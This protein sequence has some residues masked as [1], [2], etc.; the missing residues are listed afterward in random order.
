VAKA[1]T[2]PKQQ[3][4]TLF[5]AP[6]SAGDPVFTI[7]DRYTPRQLYT[8]V[9]GVP[10]RWPGQR[11]VHLVHNWR[12]GGS[13]LTALL[14]V[15]LH[16]SYL[17]VGHPFTRDGWP[18]NYGLHP[19]QITRAEQLIQWIRAQPS[20]AILAG[21][22][23]AGMAAKLGLKDAELWITLREPAA[24][25][26]SGLLRFHRKALKS[27]HPDGGYVGRTKGH[28][29]STAAEIE[30]VSKQ[31]LSHELNGL[32]RRI[33]GYSMLPSGASPHPEDDLETCR[34]LDERPVDQAC[35][36]LAMDHLNSSAWIYL[37]EQVIPSLLLLEHHYGL[38]PLIHPC[39]NLVHN[40]QWNGAGITRLQES[41]LTHHRGLLESLNAWDVKLYT[42]A[43]RLFWKRWKQADIDPDRLKARRILQGKPLLHQK[44]L[45]QPEEAQRQMKSK[46]KFRA[47]KETS[48]AVARWIQQDGEAASFWA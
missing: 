34:E 16:D 46:I 11:W 37:T 26:N 8:P 43:K 12:T 41:L 33:A 3:Q 19:L 30:A 42:E 6:T 28:T 18:V 10:K 17:K 38:R 20:P 27:D 44:L 23:Y 31:E 9:F 21:H 14:S 45:Q 1:N 48:P 15:N 4:G 35:F 36:D 25:L 24:R 29:F 22:T 47:Q 13:S 32:C 7:A 40:P 5:P 2:T 39:S